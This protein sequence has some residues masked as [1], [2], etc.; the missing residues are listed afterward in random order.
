MFGMWFDE[1]HDKTLIIFYYVRIEWGNIEYGNVSNDK[2]G[3][4]SKI[5]S[6]K[7]CKQHSRS[8]ISMHHIEI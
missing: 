5:V 4:C 8:G 2:W 3:C 6:D 7:I 1:N